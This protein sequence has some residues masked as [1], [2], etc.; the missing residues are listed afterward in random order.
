MKALERLETTVAV[1]VESSF[2]FEFFPSDSNINP[3]L[4]LKKAQIAYDDKTILSDANIYIGS[5]SRIGLLGP[6]GAGKSTL[7]KVLAQQLQIKNGE[8]I[9]H[10]A[11]RI[12]YFAQHQY[13][14]LQLD[15]SPLQHLRDIDKQATESNLR[16]FLGR[17]GFP[18]DRALQAITNFSGGEKARLALALLVWQRPNLLLLDEPTNHLDLEMRDAL[19]LALQEYDGAMVI[20]SHDRYLLSMTADQLI[21]VSDGLVQDFS[22]DIAEYQKW[23]LE[24]RRTQIKR[25]SEINSFQGG[26]AKD[27][28]S[29][30][31][32]RRKLQAKLDKLD[33]QLITL[34]KALD[35]VTQLLSDPESYEDSQQ[36]LLQRRIIEQTQLRNQIKDIEAEWL[37]TLQELEALDS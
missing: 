9:T 32:V 16:N 4:Q 23:L 7:M 28:Q 26:S 15:E 34:N 19:L 17:F 3:L 36:Q 18:G 24:Q 25:E 31:K 1:H 5:G 2:S 6:N 13:D 21:L 14:Y 20:V 29:S 30:T 27:N 37:V 10:K 33:G 22:G 12:G 11:L 8:Q 35:E